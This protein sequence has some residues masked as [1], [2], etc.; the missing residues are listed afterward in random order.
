MSAKSKFRG[1]DIEYINYKWLFCATKLP[2][3][4]N[5][6]IKCGFCGSENTKEGFD[7]CMGSL[8][9]VKNACC[10]H[11]QADEAYVQYSDGMTIRGSCAGCIITSHTHGDPHSLSTKHWND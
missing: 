7:G 1:H 10:G 8:P 6:N 11:G 9:E 5:P 3:K 4:D 2:V